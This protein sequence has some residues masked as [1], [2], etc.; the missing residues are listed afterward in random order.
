M[1]SA[2]G[3]TVVDPDRQVVRTSGGVYVNPGHWAARLVHAFRHWTGQTT[4]LVWCGITVDLE[5]GARL[6]GDT[7]SCQQ[8]SQASWVALRSTLR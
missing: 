7:I 5:E 2:R 8:C 3:G 1:R 6:T 4:L